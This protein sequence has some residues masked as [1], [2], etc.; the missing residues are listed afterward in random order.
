MSGESSCRRGRCCFSSAG[1]S[2][3]RVAQVR[4]PVPVVCD[5]CV[6]SAVVQQQRHGQL[7]AADG[8]LAVGETLSRTLARWR[9]RSQCPAVEL[10]HRAA[11][12]AEEE[13]SGRQ[14]GQRPSVAAAGHGGRTFGPK[15]RG[16]QE[17]RASRSARPLRR[18]SPRA[19]S[20]TQIDSA[21]HA[22][23]ARSVF[24]P[25]LALARRFR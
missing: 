4:C 16:K 24:R 20:T 14:V 10:L 19:P 5:C 17:R 23:A 18:P 12:S 22:T 3:D 25:G 8:R 11:P 7:A 2:I 9:S 15:G 13:K 6:C 1:V 21:A